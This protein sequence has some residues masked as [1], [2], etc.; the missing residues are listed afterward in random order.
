[1][2]FSIY[3]ASPW[4]EFDIQGVNVAR[5]GRMVKVDVTNV[6]KG[7]AR[8]D[9]ASKERHRWVALEGEACYPEKG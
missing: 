3:R 7:E 6:E 5:V 1:V 4:E 8:K 2:G 9:G